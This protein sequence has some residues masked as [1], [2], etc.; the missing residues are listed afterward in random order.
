MEKRTM[1]IVQSMGPAP[2]L[3]VCTHCN[4]QFKVPADVIHTVEAATDNLQDQF[5]RHKCRLVDSSQ[6][7][8]RIVR[9]STEG[10]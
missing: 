1:R 3:A 7:A 4:Q 8:L 6:N 2:Y 9:E 10:K 5:A